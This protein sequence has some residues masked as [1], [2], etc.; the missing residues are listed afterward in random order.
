MV[1]VCACMSAIQE[2]I[3][4]CYFFFKLIVKISRAIFTLFQSSVTLSVFF[5]LLLQHNLFVLF[6]KKI[7]S[8]FYSLRYCWWGRVGLGRPVWDPSSLPTTLPEIQEDWEPQVSPGHP[9]TKTSMY[10]FTYI[11]LKIMLIT[12]HA[13]HCDVGEL[14]MMMDLWN[15]AQRSRLNPSNFLNCLWVSGSGSD[16][17]KIPVAKLLN[18]VNSIV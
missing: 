2:A 4:L 11:P 1:I 7:I 6:F 13:F 5:S 16:R 18:R 15:A 3:I 12:I 17:K 9:F 14:V 8:C 10:K